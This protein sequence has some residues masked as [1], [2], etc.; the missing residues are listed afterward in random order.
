MLPVE[1]PPATCGDGALEV[2]V[3]QRK[4]YCMKMTSF[5]LLVE[6]AV[7]QKAVCGAKATWVAARVEE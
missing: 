3:V 6:D 5:L 7:G 1:Q 2:W 4:M